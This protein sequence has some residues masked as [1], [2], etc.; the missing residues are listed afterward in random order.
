MTGNLHVSPTYDTQSSVT[1]EMSVTTIV[2]LGAVVNFS[3]SSYK[4]IVLV[5][6]E[7]VGNVKSSVL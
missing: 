5:G 3:L 2:Y 4:P 6:L 7:L 1:A